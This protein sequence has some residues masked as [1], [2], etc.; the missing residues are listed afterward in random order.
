M[1]NKY[2]ASTEDAD[3]STALSVNI[4]DQ[5]VALSVNCSTSISL[6]LMILCHCLII[7]IS[8]FL[9]GLYLCHIDSTRLIIASS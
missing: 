8:D 7:Y 2:Q 4:R 6:L 3:Q 5:S 1:H 9:I